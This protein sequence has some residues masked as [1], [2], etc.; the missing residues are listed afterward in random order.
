MDM[1]IRDINYID[2]HQCYVIDD[3][4]DFKPLVRVQPRQV[5]KRFSFK[6]QN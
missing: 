6:G 2:T 5:D 3:R 4:N 1:T